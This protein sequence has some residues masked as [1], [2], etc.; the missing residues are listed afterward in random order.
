[1]PPRLS[2]QAAGTENDAA[3][4]ALAMKLS[5]PVSILISMQSQSNFGFAAGPDGDG[6]QYKLDLQPVIPFSI[7]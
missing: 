3:E 4:I 5:N 2:A 6:F 1:M 7:S